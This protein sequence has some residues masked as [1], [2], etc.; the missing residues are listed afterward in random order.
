MVNQNDP[1]L[2]KI[3][4]LVHN[5]GKNYDGFS[6]LKGISFSIQEGEIFGLL[7]PNGAGKSTCMKIIC[8]LLAPTYGHALIDGTD[9]TKNPI[10]AKSKIGY[11]PEYPALFEHLSGREFLSM[12]G[13]F[14]DLKKDD[15]KYRIEKLNE[16]LDLEGKMDNLIGTYSKG[17][18]QKIAFASAIIHDPPILILDE[19]TSGLDPRFGRYV[20]DIIKEFGASKKTILMSTHIT[21]VAQDLCNKMA[22]I[23]KGEIVI[24]GTV[25]EVKNKTNSRTLEE[26]FI[27]VVGGRI[28]T[29]SIFTPKTPKNRGAPSQKG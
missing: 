6:A 1:D 27:N 13:K 3:R 8:G 26:A 4:L 29:G 5:L 28:W 25:S 14:R 7:G 19:P 22:I 15:N 2:Q 20:R 9:V 24:S 17:M 12:I 23:N 21:E 11:L 16:V 10:A 18:R